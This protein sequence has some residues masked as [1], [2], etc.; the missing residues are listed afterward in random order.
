MQ[1]L[2]MTRWSLLTAAAP[3][4]IVGVPGHLVS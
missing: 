3:I 4:F 1:F 2:Q